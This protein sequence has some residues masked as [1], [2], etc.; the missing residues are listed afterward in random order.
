MFFFSVIVKIRGW[1]STTCLKNEIADKTSLSQPITST[2]IN[3]GVLSIPDHPPECNYRLDMNNMFDHL[4]VAS[5]NAM[6]STKW[7]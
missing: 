7:S 3:I 2:I 4:R 5:I 1:S 6:S